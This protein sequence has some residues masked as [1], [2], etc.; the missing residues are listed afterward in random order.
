VLAKRSQLSL[1]VSRRRLIVD[2]IATDEANPLVADLAERLYAHE[3]GIV[4]FRAG[5]EARALEEFIAAIAVSPARAGEPLGAAGRSQLARWNDIALTRVAFDRLELMGDRTE[6]REREAPKA[7]RFEELWLG[8]ARAALGGESLDGA[9]ED[10]KRLAESIDRHLS[11]ERYDQAI[12]S[13]LRQIIGEL[14]D[15]AM[16]DAALR[17]RVSDL[18]KNLDDATLSTL[19]RM[20]G[21]APGETPFLERACE[22]LAAGAVVHLT[23]VAARDA[24]APIAGSMLRLLAK[25]A[26]DAES[27][28]A[29]S[30]SADRALR[31]V[32]HGCSRTGSSS[33]PIP[34]HIQLHST[35]LPSRA[36]SPSPTSAATA[37][38]RS[39]SCR[40][41]SPATRS[42]QP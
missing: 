35:A 2:G 13:Y 38:N 36:S 4:A 34:R 40:S 23:R 10:P 14:G 42:V 29:T 41:A 3:L 31:G 18:V 24:G 16:R 21:D 1:G 26:R 20:G 7:Q 25:L 15:G 27:R 37:A 5:L 11:R 6:E 33:L 19:L 9:L 30:R 32:I 28:G 39:G 12:L 17:Q 22:S 8:L